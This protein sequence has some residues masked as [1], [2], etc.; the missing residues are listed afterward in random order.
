[1][2]AQTAALNHDIFRLLKHP[3]APHQSTRWE[4]WRCSCLLFTF[5]DW[6]ACWS[7]SQWLNTV[8]VTHNNAN[9]HQ[10]FVLIRLN[11]YILSISPFFFP[12]IKVI[13]DQPEHCFGHLSLFLDGSQINLFKKCDAKLMSHLQL[14][15]LVL[16]LLTFVYFQLTL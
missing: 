11:S 14:R 16:Y 1:M 3:H 15:M 8:V 10:F 13:V 12:S 4:M 2:L 7:S 5:R 6:A 9:N